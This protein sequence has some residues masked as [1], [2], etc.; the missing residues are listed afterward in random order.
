MLKI[1]ETNYNEELKYVQ[2]LDQNRRD[3]LKRKLCD[4][5]GIFYLIENVN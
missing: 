3:T 1:S 4:M 2:F 5:K